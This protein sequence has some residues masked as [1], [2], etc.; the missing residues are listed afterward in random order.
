MGDPWSSDADIDIGS[1]ATNLS[2][3]YEAA[4]VGKPFY[5]PGILPV[6]N[7]ARQGV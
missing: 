7:Y 1:R 4:D 3:E 2:Q 6:T 5:R